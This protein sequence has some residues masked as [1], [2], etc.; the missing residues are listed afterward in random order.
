MNLLFKSKITEIIR[1]FIFGALMLFLSSKFEFLWIFFLILLLAG[2]LTGQFTYINK[3]PVDR[4]KFKKYQLYNYGFFMLLL[5][6]FGYKY[7]VF[8]SNK[9][10]V[11]QIYWPV[12]L[13][14]YLFN[15]KA[16]RE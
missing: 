5:L 3:N 2:L 8:F 7:F 1:V 6:I 10:W 12:Y 16:V 15:L 13:G 4:I 9:T 14:T 11:E